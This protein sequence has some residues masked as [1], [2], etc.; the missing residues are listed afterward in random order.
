MRF[1]RGL[2][3]GGGNLEQIEQARRDFDARNSGIS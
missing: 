2:D 1:L 3:L